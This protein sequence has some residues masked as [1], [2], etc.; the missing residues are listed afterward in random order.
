MN[1]KLKP[2]NVPNF[3]LQQM[4]AGH[5]NDVPSYPLKDIPAED[6]AEL[7]DTFRAEIF[8]KAGK[9]DPECHTPSSGDNENE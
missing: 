6:L 8:R 1:I 7:C 5:R 2:F 4:P 3:A 9:T